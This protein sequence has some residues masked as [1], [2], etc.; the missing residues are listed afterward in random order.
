MTDKGLPQAH[1]LFKPAKD[2][3][4]CLCIV[5]FEDGDYWVF[6]S[7]TGTYAAGHA[8]RGK[9]RLV[10]ENYL[11]NGYVREAQA[12]ANGLIPSSWS[13]STPGPEPMWQRKFRRRRAV[14]LL[15]L[16]VVFVLA[17]VG[18]IK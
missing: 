15:V 3:P 9:W 7:P 6:D 11:A 10:E 18:F 8:D 4:S 14:A 2:E 16:F 17:W 5:E 1:W 12:K 13:R